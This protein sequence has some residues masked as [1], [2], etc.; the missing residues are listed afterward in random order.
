MAR[1]LGEIVLGDVEG[2]QYAVAALA[3]RVERD[4]GQGDLDGDGVSP[5]PGEFARQG[6]QRVQAQLAQLFALGDDPVVVPAR[7]E[8]DPGCPGRLDVAVN[9]RTPADQ[10]PC[11]HGECGDIDLHLA[12]HE[13]VAVDHH[14]PGA[15]LD[16]PPQRGAEVAVRALVVHLGPQQAGHRAPRQPAPH[17]EQRHEALL[18]ETG[19]QDAAVELELETAQQR[20]M[21]FAGRCCRTTAV[22]VGCIRVHVVPPLG[23]RN[24]AVGRRIVRQRPIGVPFPG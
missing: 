1:R 19:P 15:E 3:Q 4:G 22:G 20:E 14:Q 18:A 16:Q 6:L 17:R 12:Q 24:H 23:R 13:M 7:Q 9:H 21:E 11:P 5:A 10:P 8:L 2:D